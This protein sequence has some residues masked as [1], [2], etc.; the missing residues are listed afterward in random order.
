MYDRR[1]AY[2][3]KAKSSGLRSR[4]AFKL[5]DLAPGVL[6]AGDRVVDLGAWPGGW[7]QVASRIVGPTGLVVGVDL[8]EIPALG[9]ANVRLLSGDVRDE[10]TIEAIGR[11][12]GGAGATAVLSDMAP[13]LSGIREH[14]Q[15]R[16]DELASLAL[17]TALRLLEPGGGFVC[18]LF[19]SPSHEGLVKDVRAAFERVSVK[20]PPATRKGSSELYVVA[21]GRKS[22][23]GES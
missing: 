14:D 10:G 17:S 11:A 7:L 4:A 1:D 18:K 6:R 5:E 20:H 16:M 19:M 21:R 2:S 12:L 22:P 8:V 3:R 9:L 15:A 23:A 13:K